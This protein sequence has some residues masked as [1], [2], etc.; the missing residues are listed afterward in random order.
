MQDDE[1]SRRQRADDIR[2]QIARLQSNEE[3]ASDGTE[4]K[5]GESPNEY[6]ERREREIR[7][8]SKDK[9]PQGRP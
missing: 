6:M 9:L 3:L 7:K 2:R 1:T 5:P 4:M 8:H